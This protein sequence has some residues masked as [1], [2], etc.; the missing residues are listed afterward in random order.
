MKL[1]TIEEWKE[2]TPKE[3]VP[4][5][6]CDCAGC[7][8]RLRKRK[9]SIMHHSV[10]EEFEQPSKYCRVCLLAGHDLVFPRKYEEKIVD[11]KVR[12]GKRLPTTES[13][14]EEG[15]EIQRGM[16]E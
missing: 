7:K 9:Y 15:R 10:L 11:G 4:S 12:Y 8:T 16:H 2:M 3:V 13:M 1:F 5:G 6:V 14:I